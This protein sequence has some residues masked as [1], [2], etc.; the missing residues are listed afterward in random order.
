M[1]GVYFCEY[2][3]QALGTVSLRFPA[4][5][6]KFAQNVENHLAV[7]NFGRAEPGEIPGPAKKFVEMTKGW[8]PDRPPE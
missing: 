1:L 7:T 5:A 2:P 6:G 3:A 8:R 4:C